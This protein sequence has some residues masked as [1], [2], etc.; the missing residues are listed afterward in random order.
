MPMWS[1]DALNTRFQKFLDGID[2]S[3]DEEFDLVERLVVQL[4]DDIIAMAVQTEWASDVLAVERQTF[5]D[6][7]AQRIWSQNETF[8]AQGAQH[9]YVLARM[10]WDAREHDRQAHA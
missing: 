1:R 6:R 10:L 4:R 2:H 3:N 7:T 5:L 9:A 8:T